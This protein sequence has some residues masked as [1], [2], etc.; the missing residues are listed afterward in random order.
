L[1]ERVEHRR[2]RVIEEPS[3]VEPGRVEHKPVGGNSTDA[4]T[5]HGVDQAP[6]CLGIGMVKVLINLNVG[7]QEQDLSS[8]HRLSQCRA[9]PL[10]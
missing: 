7:D 9:K 1:D 10:V 4:G 3:V 2:G 5:Q 6:G 8:I